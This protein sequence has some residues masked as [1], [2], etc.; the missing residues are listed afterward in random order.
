MVEYRRGLE[1]GEPV[2]APPIALP[3]RKIKTV[4]KSTTSSIGAIT[5]GKDGDGMNE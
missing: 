5:S 2:R 1:A 3:P 4:E